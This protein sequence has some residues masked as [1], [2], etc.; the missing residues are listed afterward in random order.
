MNCFELTA[1]QSLLKGTVFSNSSRD[2]LPGASIFLDGKAFAVTDI[3]G[4]FSISLDSGKHEI[5]FKY[6]SFIDKSITLQLKKNEMK[7][8]NIFL[9]DARRELDIIV[10]SASKF[11]QKVEAV[12]VSMEV[13]SAK[14]VEERNTTSLDDAMQHLNSVSIIDGQANIRGGSGWSYGAGS[15][16]QILV[17]DLPQLTADANDAKWSFLPVENLE[18][19][20]VIKGASSVLFGSSALNGVI[21]IRTAYPK[22]KPLTKIN[23]F[24]GIYDHANYTLNDTSYQADWWGS[25]PQL[26]NGINF[27]HSRQAGRLDVVVG[28]NIFLDE[29]YR[30]GEHE[31][32]ARF[33]T[34][35]RYRFKKQEG[36]S[37][38][39]NFNTMKTEG[40]LFFLWKNDTSGAYIP[41]SNTLS[42]YTTYRTNV[43]PFITYFDKKGNTHKLRTRFFNTTNRNNTNQESKADLYYGEYQ[44]QHRFKKNLTITTGLVGQISKVNSEL[45]GDH[46][47][48]QNAIYLQGDYTGKR[49][50]LSLGG[51]IEQNKADSVQDEWTP[52]FRC[53]LNYRIHKATYVRASYG[54]GYRFPS[55]AEK[56]VRT[57]VGDLNIYPNHDLIPEKGY[58]QEFGIRQLYK[59]RSWSGYLDIAAFENR[60]YN[61]MEFGFAQWGTS[62]DPFIGLGFKSLNVG[63]TRIQG[64]DISLLTQGTL[65][66]SV[67]STWSAGY[68]YIE[69]TQLSYDSTYIVKVGLDNYLGSDSSDVLKYRY[70]HLLKADVEFQWRRISVGLSLRYHSRMINIDKIF[71]S[72][73]LDIAFKPALGI[74]HY[75]DNHKQGDAIFD[76]RSSIQVTKELQASFIVKNLFN[77]VYMERPADMQPPRIYVIQLGLKF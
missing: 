42:N 34:N 49:L 54:Q 29:G 66:R 15:R 22:E 37:I 6:I 69:P 50:T 55:I 48:N 10:V 13:I 17:D 73:F 18:Q 67:K 28:G 60:Y 30:K 21:N 38:G 11:E 16:V 2:P 8:M 3:N 9:E 1:Q 27:M 68:T 43:D 26:Y 62:A 25:I 12:T 63:D 20:E 64:I 24:T 41:A 61:M 65:F 75:R 71:T 35:L 74:G 57:A 4:T 7:V 23:V 76:L 39:A 59:L 52:V 46:K 77:H 70:T 51:R 58:S 19:I 53:G 36:L 14:L 47:G 72:G 33:N 5:V 32:R 40:T 44:F 56:F 31:E 45:Y